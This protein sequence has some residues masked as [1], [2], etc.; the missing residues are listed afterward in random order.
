MAM[1]T[2]WIS[3]AIVANWRALP[4]VLMLVIWFFFSGFR[5]ILKTKQRRAVKEALLCCFCFGVLFSLM[6]FGCYGLVDPANKL[7]RPGAV[8]VGADA[9]AR[10][11]FF[12]YASLAVAVA[13]GLLLEWQSR[14][15][16][17]LERA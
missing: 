3:G 8:P 11:A 4:V 5:S 13:A 14:R 17:P 7:V 10:F 9:L 6:C 12:G 16:A 15:G 2:R 1:V